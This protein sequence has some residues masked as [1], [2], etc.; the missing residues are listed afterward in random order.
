VRIRCDSLREL[1][2]YDGV[3]SLVLVDSSLTPWLPGRQVD[4]GQVRLPGLFVDPS[5][6]AGQTKGGVLQV[7]HPRPIRRVSRH[8]LK[9]F[10]WENRAWGR[11]R[12]IARGP[13]DVRDGRWSGGGG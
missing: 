6:H 7:E 13:R 11:A 5:L 12:T 8:N 3:V 4:A 1:G 10:L 9:F 2:L